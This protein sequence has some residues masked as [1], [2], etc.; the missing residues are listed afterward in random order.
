[1]ENW[2]ER[3]DC[4]AE[5]EKTDGSCVV[6]AVIID[7][8]CSTHLCRGVKKVNRMED[9]MVT[10][11]SVNCAI[12]SPREFRHAPVMARVM[13][14]CES[15]ECWYTRAIDRAAIVVKEEDIYIL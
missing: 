4:E 2:I 14:G 5:T 7:M 15:N 11:F 6:V 9:M 3:T 8:F 12:M 1:M 10:T 13:L